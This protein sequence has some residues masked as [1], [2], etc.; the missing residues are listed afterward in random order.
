MAL[1][2]L[3]LSV[4]AGRRAMLRA[5][6]ALA[7]AAGSVLMFG[8]AGAVA[9]TPSRPHIIHI[10]TDD[11]GWKDVG[12]NG[13]D[14]STPNIDKLAAG[15]L[16]LTNFYALPMCTPTRAA[17][18][19]G[20]YPFRYGLQTGVIP[21]SGKYG[22]ATDE[23]LMP[24]ML[25]EA[26]YRTAMV[27]KWHLG[28]ARTEFW[29][30]QRGFDSSYGPLIGEIDHFTHK[31]HGIV[32]WYRDN[33]R[34]DEKGY[35]TTL[36]GNEAV[37][38]ISKHDPKTPLYLY[39]AFTAPHTPYQAPKEWLDKYSRI[40]DPSRRAY[41]A[42]ISAMDH[43][44][45]RVIAALEK[46]GML[47]N[48]LIV[49]HTDNGGTRD[50]MFAGEAEVK[51]ELP[52][53]NGPFRAGKGTLREGGTRVA[54]VVKWPGRVAPGKADGLMH[55][56]DLYPTFAAAAGARPTKNKPLDGMDM[57]AFLTGAVPSPRTEIVY[58][59]E[60]YRAAVRQGDMKLLWVPILPGSVELHDLG[61]DPSEATNLAG[62][63]PEAVEKLKARIADLAREAVPP[64]LLGAMIA[65]TYGA[66]PVWPKE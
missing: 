26:G 7:L 25:K 52:P 3:S 19:T 53:D 62:D 45:G 21:S 43:E 28:H 9:Q 6:G 58:N 40:A 35:D 23:F 63:Q 8:Q 16:T 65:T 55:V 2:A 64:L 14:I 20:R 34:L 11:Q 48:S 50:N 32:D 29:P 66:A 4:L 36:F 18:M 44:I 39:L 54:A 27:G 22:L 61:R 42:Q 46:R 5:A 17:I 31:S 59:L 1:S 57:S 49:Y 51:G 37:R 10:L 41:A 30:R 24:Q 56:V 15:G 33:K 12:F 13:S 47:Q 60:P 38:L